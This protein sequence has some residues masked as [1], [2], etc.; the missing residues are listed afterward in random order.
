M[1]GIDK[2]E[3]VMDLLSKTENRKVKYILSG[4]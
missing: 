3:I 4:G 1:I 2:P